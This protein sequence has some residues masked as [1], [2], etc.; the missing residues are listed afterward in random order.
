MNII[1]QTKVSDVFPSFRHIR[2]KDT[3]V[4]EDKWRYIRGTDNKTVLRF[5]GYKAA[6]DFI[7][8]LKA[9]P[10]D[11]N[12]YLYMNK[13]KGRETGNLF[14]KFKHNIIK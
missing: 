8:R 5:K 2:W 14:F 10:V 1:Y 11:E 3:D 4:K 12:P 7:E 13:C 6:N 9:I